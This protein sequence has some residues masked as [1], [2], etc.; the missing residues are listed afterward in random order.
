MILVEKRTHFETTYKVT[1]HK[2][3]QDDTK[4]NKSRHLRKKSRTSFHSAGEIL[5]LDSI[6][7]SQMWSNH[8][9]KLRNAKLISTQMISIMSCHWFFM[10]I[11]IYHMCTCIYVYVYVYIYIIYVY[12]IY[13]LSTYETAR[14]LCLCLFPAQRHVTIPKQWRM[15]STCP[16]APTLKL[17]ILLTSKLR[18]ALPNSIKLWKTNAT[19]TPNHRNRLS[20]LPVAARGAMGA[21]SGTC[22]HPESVRCWYK[23]MNTYCKLN[24]YNHE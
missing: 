21:T 11:A 17:K 13:I 16:G 23:L 6:C 1:K 7:Q 18:F 2:Q 19:K 12:I 4:G 24:K 15:A 14:P 3:S 5:I 22:N 20:L 8:V 10:I 9:I